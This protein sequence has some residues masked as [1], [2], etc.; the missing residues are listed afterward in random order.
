M[1]FAGVKVVTSL[2]MTESRTIT[3]KRTI[4]ER[5]FTRPWRPLQKTKTRTIQV[6][7]ED[8]IMMDGTIVMHPATLEKFKRM[9]P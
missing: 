9:R 1:M 7:R 8:S 6:P 2:W 5:L 3:E 4:R